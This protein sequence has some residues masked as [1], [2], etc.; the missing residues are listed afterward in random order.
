MVLSEAL[1][2]DHS[3][4]FRR[5]TTCHDAHMQITTEHI[6]SRDETIEAALKASK[7]SSQRAPVRRTFV[8]HRAGPGGNRVGPG[9]LAT[10]VRQGRESALDQ[11]LLLVAWASASDQLGHY[12]VRRAASVWARA[13]GLPNDAR[14]RQQVS[15]NWKLLR[16][17]ELV[18]TATV[19]RQ[20][21]AWLLQ[22]DGLGKVYRPPARDYLALPYAYWRSG[23][24]E[25]LDLP[26]KAMLLVFL[27]LPPR[28]PLPFNRAPEWYG[29]SRATAERGIRSLR[30]FDLLETVREPI[31][32]PLAPDGYSIR[33]VYTLAGDFRLR[34]RRPQHDEQA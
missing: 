27:T 1:R 15:R 10:F 5:R 4:D 23:W 28:S 18:E 26:A 6:A 32:A 22:E 12:G 20:T 29:L 9:P 24:H 8:Q 7:R 2:R 17:L 31:K 33:N 14:G 30:R 34:R 11:F 21:S 19:K 25:Q 16:E 3:D 13:L